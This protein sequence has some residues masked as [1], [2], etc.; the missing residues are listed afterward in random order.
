[1]TDAA[2]R[3]LPMMRVVPSGRRLQM[4]F[5]AIWIAFAVLIVLSALFIPRSLLPSSILSIIPFAAFLTITAMG[6]ALVLMARGIDLSIPATITLSS[7]L[8]LGVSGGN[9]DALLPAIIVALIFSLAVGLVIGVLIAVFRLNSLVVTLAI[10]TIVIG[11]TIWYREGIVAEARVP[12]SLADW[13]GSRFLEVNVAVWIALAV[14]V[15]STIILRLTAVGRRFIAVGASPRAAWIAGI[16]VV[17]YQV[18]AYVLAALL[19]GIAGI[20]LSAFIRNPTLDVGQ[21]Y[22]LAP[23]AAAVLGGTAVSGGVGSMIA[24]AGAALFLTQLD[25]ILKMLG[26]STAIQFIVYGGAIAVG[27]ALGGVQVTRYRTLIARWF[28]RP[29]A[30]GRGNA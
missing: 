14:V 16:G 30:Q 20:L 3:S 1:M 24:I 11:A 6:E 12:P 26:V 5:A 29:A 28:A 13:G 18:A 23:I 15:L 19:Y 9:D 10:G 4:R 22:L 25:Q 2:E 27:M 21:P 17:R 7:T 8:L